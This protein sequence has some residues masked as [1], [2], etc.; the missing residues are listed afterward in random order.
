MTITLPDELKDE[1]ERKAQAAGFLS[2][3]DYVCW[4]VRSA[5]AGDAEPTPRDFGFADEA[6]ME[7]KLQAALD[8]GPPITVTP[9]FWDELRKETIA[10]AERLKGRE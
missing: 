4:L 1:L 9:D 8:S 2:A 5:D 10:R 3:S 7:A 6:E